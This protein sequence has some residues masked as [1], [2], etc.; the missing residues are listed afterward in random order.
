MNIFDQN[1]I[2]DQHNF[3]YQDNIID[4]N[5]IFF[6]NNSFDVIPAMQTV[7]LGY[8]STP[9]PHLYILFVHI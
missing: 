3:L 1:N 7:K 4:Q 6:Q 9:Q 5:N 8:N 2:F